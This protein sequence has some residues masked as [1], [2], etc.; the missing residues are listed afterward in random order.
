MQ[1]STSEQ[2]EEQVLGEVDNQL[3]Q[4]V[5]ESAFKKL[6]SNKKKRKRKG[7]AHAIARTTNG[8]TTLG[9]TVHETILDKPKYSYTEQS[10]YSRT[11]Q[12][13]Y[14]HCQRQR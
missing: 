3:N 2:I 4:T 8:T 13:G 10:K 9:E 1:K 12:Y 11:N 7:L 5:C 14:N 6:S